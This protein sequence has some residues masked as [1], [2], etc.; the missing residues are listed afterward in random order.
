MQILITGAAGYLGRRLVTMLSQSGH[1][2][3]ALTRGERALPANETDAVI[4]TATCYGR[5]GESRDEVFA[6]N[7]DW[8]L[9]LLE[10]LSPGTV[11]V[12]T[13]TVLA[14]ALNGYAASKESFRQRG[15]DLARARNVRWFNLRLEHFYGP[16]EGDDKFITRTVRA[17]L[18]G[19]ELK[20]TPGNQRRD[21]VFID[22]VVS[23][24]D[25]VLRIA[26]ERCDA[27]DLYAGTGRPVRIRDLVE[28]INRLCGS[29]GGLCFGTIPMRE[30]EPMEFKSPDAQPLGDYGWQ[31]S[32]DLEQGL[33]RVVRFEKARAYP[34]VCS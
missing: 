20:L 32:V 12:N 6:A 19:S 26:G 1:R 10:T 15:H 4:H 16:G 7:V 3:L 23:A 11:F 27:G 17:C 14:P 28:R 9:R 21:F 34:C 5:A 30:D 18:A 22:D 2:V 8:P 25:R 24:F 31:A 13:D 33:E 29:R